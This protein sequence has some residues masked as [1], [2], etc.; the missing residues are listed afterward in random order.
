MQQCGFIMILFLS[1]DVTL[2]KC[3]FMQMQQCFSLVYQFMKQCFIILPNYATE[4]NHA[5]TM[6]QLDRQVTITYSISCF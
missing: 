1:S 3:L 6:F 4:M 2:V 5:T